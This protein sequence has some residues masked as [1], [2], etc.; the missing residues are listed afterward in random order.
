VLE[1]DVKLKTMRKKEKHC[2]NRQH[3]S[4]TTGK[5]WP[6]NTGITIVIAT[7]ALTNSNFFALGSE[8]N[9]RECL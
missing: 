2:E 8:A 6:P 7:W 3:D 1:R 9:S 5:P 4:W